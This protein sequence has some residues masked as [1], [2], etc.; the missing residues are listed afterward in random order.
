MNST[1]HEKGFI[2]G[3]FPI[4]CSSWSISAIPLIIMAVWCIMGRN[5]YSIALGIRPL[6]EGESIDF[7][8]FGQWEVMMVLP[9]ILDGFY[10]N[11]IKKIN[12]F[13]RIRLT[14]SKE[15]RKLQLSGCMINAAFWSFII[16]LIVKIVVKKIVLSMAAVILT[17]Q[18]L[19]GAS[20]A[21]VNGIG[22][23]SPEVSGVAVMTGFGAVHLLNEYGILPLFASP[24]AWG[25]VYRSTKYIQ[26]G[27]TIQYMITGNI[28]LSVLFA[29]ILITRPV[30]LEE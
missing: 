6:Q 21:L 16:V 26:T 8:A 24:A 12:I 27:I 1:K 28:L 25:M 4:Y 20:Y 22:K 3:L 2:N 5:T 14:G 13:V 15:Y 7:L 10:L 9:I 23:L 29:I 17:S 11:N 18:I 19:W 30:N